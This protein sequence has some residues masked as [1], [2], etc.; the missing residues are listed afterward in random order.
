[1]AG[2]PNKGFET[3]IKHFAQPWK[4]AEGQVVCQ[5]EIQQ[6]VE[7][8]CKR[9]PLMLRAWGWRRGW[10]IQLLSSAVLAGD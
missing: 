8:V 6:W 5:F 2:L 9:D 3:K 10:S 4:Y 1:M 7:A